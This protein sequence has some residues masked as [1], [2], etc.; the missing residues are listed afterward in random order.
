MEFFCCEVNVHVESMDL[1]LINT[2]KEVLLVPSD[3]L[4]FQVWFIEAIDEEL[5]EGPRSK[6]TSLPHIQRLKRLESNDKSPYDRDE[7]HMVSF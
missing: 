5:M 3:V 1:K 7:G 4:P 6:V 2:C